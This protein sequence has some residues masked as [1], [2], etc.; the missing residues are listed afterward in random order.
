MEKWRQVWREGL[1]GQF[2]L[3]ALEALRGALARD[4]ERLVQH[5]TTCPP[6]MDVFSAAPVECAC[7]LGFCG[8]QG[9][10]KTTVGQV[11]DYFADLCQ[12]ADERMGQPGACRHFLVWFDEM[13]RHLMRQE[14][15]AEVTMALNER[16]PRVRRR[17]PQRVHAA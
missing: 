9:E 13:P 15:L 6:C 8:W 10:S 14:L 17:M 3:P 16:Y 7:A 1:V 4:D 12:S 2:S 5:V 11:Q